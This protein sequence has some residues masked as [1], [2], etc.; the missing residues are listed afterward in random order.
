MWDL[1]KVLI[2]Y[3]IKAI[4]YY[5]VRSP[6]L[7]EW[8]ANPVI[9]EA[10]RAT[11]ERTFADLDP[12]FNSNIDEDFDFRSSGITRHSFCSVTVPPATSP[13]HLT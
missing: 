9:A 12:I 5:T 3:Y 2:S 1:R 7:A 11:T 10:V 4:I 8:L 13:G 6:K